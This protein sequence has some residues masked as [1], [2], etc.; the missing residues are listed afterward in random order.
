MCNDEINPRELVGLI[1][2][3]IRHRRKQ[4]NSMFFVNLISPCLQLINGVF[5]AS[6]MIV[7]IVAD[8]CMAIETK[9]YCIINI[10][11]ALIQMSYLYTHARKLAT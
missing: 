2:N 9:W 3:L 6:R 4:A 1:V 10:I 7:I 11:A 8:S 5:F